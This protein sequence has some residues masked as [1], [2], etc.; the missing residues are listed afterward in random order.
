M[1]SIARHFLG[2]GIRSIEP[3]G[4]GHIHKTFLVI[5]PKGKYVLQEINTHVFP[6]PQK[7]M[8]NIRSVND[9]LENS[10][11]PFELLK[12]L[13]NQDGNLLAYSDRQVFRMFPF[14]ENA[15][16]YDIADSAELT[17]VAAEAMAIFHQY[18]FDLPASSLSITIPGFFV[19]N[20]RIS[21]FQQAVSSNTSRVKESS[22]E[23]ELITEYLDFFTDFIRET[24]QLP[25][26]VIHGDPKLNNILFHKS[27][28]K[29]Q[30]IIDLDTLMPGPLFYDFSDMIRSW[31]NESA[32]DEDDLAKVKLNS[33]FLKNIITSYLRITGPLLTA[34]EQDSLVKGYSFI[35]WI[36]AIRFLTDYFE[37][38]PYYKTS[39][40]QQ[41][42]SRARNQLHLFKQ[43]E[44]QRAEVTELINS[45]FPR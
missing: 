23:I 34:G 24:E 22:A 14:I 25:A 1:E 8:E 44:E 20:S 4:S 12:P 40:P 17:S 37:G 43:L 33:S 31:T 26:S 21:S 11:Y 10:N 27:T 3:L 19:F 5:S 2:T 36:Q 32:E 45:Y 41:N 13:T 39:Y 30:C 9:H 35:T 18:L 7:I 15:K 38:D 29:A 6:S 16:T 42:L 28:A